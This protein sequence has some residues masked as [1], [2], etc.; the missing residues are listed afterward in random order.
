MEC[1]EATH[2]SVENFSV[3]YLKVKAKLVSVGKRISSV[4]E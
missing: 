3:N 4:P 1:S 2:F